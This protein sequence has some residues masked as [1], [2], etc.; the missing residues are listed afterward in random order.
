MEVIILEA[1][2]LMNE[3][4]LR[5]KNEINKIRT[6]RVNP[7]ILERV[8]VKCYGGVD[9][10]SNIAQVKVAE[11]HQL[12]IKPYDR[13]LIKDITEAVTKADLKLQIKSEAENIRL[14][15][16]QL[17]EDVRKSLVK[18]LS[19]K[20]E[21]YKVKIRNCRRDTVQNLKKIKLPEDQEKHAETTI[22][23]LTDSKIKELV[24]I[25]NIKKAD[26]MKI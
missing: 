20:T 16:P 7:N 14:I 8:N 4:I 17:T 23:D 15:F 10:L 1:T 3:I 25:E 26:L 21:E 6:G 9:N 5:Y 24:L 22:Q 12:L 2:N 11:A 19:K 18:D 13:S